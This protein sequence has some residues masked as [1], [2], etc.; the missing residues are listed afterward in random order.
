M[1]SQPKRK[2]NVEDHQKDDTN[3]TGFKV[4]KRRIRRH[5]MYDIYK[6]LADLL[7]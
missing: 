6:N 1:K 3:K 4:L 2:E 5:N 7:F